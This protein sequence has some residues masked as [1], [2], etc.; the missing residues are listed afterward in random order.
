MAI[1]DDRAADVAREGYR[2]DVD[3]A[4]VGALLADR[5]RC[6]ILLALGDGRACPPPD[7]QRRRAPPATTAATWR[8][9]LTAVPA[10]P[11]LT[12][13]E[14]RLEEVRQRLTDA[15]LASAAV[16]VGLVGWPH[17]RDRVVQI[18]AGHDLDGLAQRSGATSKPCGSASWPIDEARAA[19]AALAQR[20]MIVLGLRDDLA[21]GGSRRHDGLTIAARFQPAEGVAA[22]GWFDVVHVGDDRVWR[23]SWSTSPATVPKRGVFALKTKYLTLSALR[24]GLS[25]GA[26][27]QWLADQLGDTGDQFL[28]GVILE[29]DT[30]A[31][32]LRYAISGHPL[33]LVSDGRSVAT[34]GPTGPLVGRWTDSRPIFR[35]RAPSPSTATGSSRPRTPTELSS[36]SSD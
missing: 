17:G 23:S 29:V 26:S 13:R 9:W 4:A 36:A 12:V 20:G 21:D 15:R 28:T 32:R 6:R 33:I 27:F 18:A 14:R 31:G 25:P 16:G 30:S 7:W 22:G 5:S 1:G 3:L 11:E 8:V 35:P 2:G 19:R 34:L 24:N 10:G